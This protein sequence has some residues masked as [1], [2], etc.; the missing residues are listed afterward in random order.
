MDGGTTFDFID[1]SP[2]K[3]LDVA[4]RAAGDEDVRI[5]GGPSIVHEFLASDLIDHLHILIV[6]IVLD[7][8]FTLWDGLA[9]SSASSMSKPKA[10]PAASPTSPRPPIA[11][12][13]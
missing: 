4:R 10:A 6:P 1:R 11:D 7:A 12:S 5:G 13:R 9:E 8:G 2:A 3:A